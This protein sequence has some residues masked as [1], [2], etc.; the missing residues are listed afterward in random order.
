MRANLPSSCPKRHDL[1]LIDRPKPR[2][3]SNGDFIMGDNI[4]CRVCGVAI[5]V[6]QNYYTCLDVCDFDVHEGCYGGSSQRQV[7]VE[8]AP[9]YIE[10]NMICPNNHSLDKRAA[11]FSKQVKN[12][13]DANIV[14]SNSIQ[15]YFCSAC[16]ANVITFSSDEFYTCSQLCDIFICTSCAEC[17]N[18]HT[19]KS[20]TNIPN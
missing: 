7:E 20:A 1:S 11:G 9:Q 16:D 15:V 19:L 8:D 5:N 10:A 13:I 6:Y 4:D 3:A 2:E 17:T 12:L 18:G 14:D